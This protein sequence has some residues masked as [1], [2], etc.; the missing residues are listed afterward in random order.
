MRMGRIESAP[1]LIALRLTHIVFG[2][3]WAGTAM[4]NAIF[5]IPAVRALGPAGAPVMQQ[6]GE[7]QNLSA[8]F[9]GSGV[10]TVLSGLGLYW[11]DSKGFT[12]EF[13]RSRGGMTTSVSRPI[14]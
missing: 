11:Y 12:G 8:Y 1:M 4:F 14:V 9:L 7:K 2:V 13:M 3:F 5:L 6:I 10:L